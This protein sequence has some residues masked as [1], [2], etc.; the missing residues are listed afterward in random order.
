MKVIETMLKEK[1]SKINSKLSAPAIGNDL[2]YKPRRTMIALEPRLMF[3]GAAAE[4]AADTVTDTKPPVQDAAAIDQEAAK[5]AEA[6]AD[7]APPAVQADPAAQRTEILF[8]EN[9]V[10]DYQTLI[11]GAKPDTEVH[12]LDASRDGLAQMAQILEGRSGIDAIHIISHGS[13][14]SVGL[15]SLT[16]TAQNLSAHAADLET[17][18]QALNPNA[19]ILLYGCDVGKGSDGAAFIS[20][21]AQ[22]THTDIAA[23][24]DLTGGS[25][26]G[27]DWT[28]EVV[29]GN[30]EAQPVVTAEQ[31]MLYDSVLAAYT[32]TISFGTGAA[33]LNAGGYS[34]DSSSNDVTYTVS[35]Y[36]L[37]IDGANR[38]VFGGDW[39]GAFLTDNAVYINPA[40]AS[41]ETSATLSFTNGE[42][43]SPGSITI[44]NDDS[45]ANNNNITLT[46]TGSNGNSIVTGSLGTWAVAASRLQTGIDLSSI[47]TVT[48]LTI[49]KTG[50]GTFR[51]I[52]IDDFA[53]SNVQAASL[54][55]PTLSAT[56]ATP[57][58]TEDGSAVD[59]F[60]GITAAT[61]DS[62]QTFSGMTLTVTNVSDTT[63][64]LVVNGI[65]VALS[66]STSGLS[67]STVGAESAGSVTVTGAGS[68]KTVTITGAALSNANMGT[69]IDGIT[70][71]DSSQAPSTASSRVVTITG[72]TD[73]GGSSNTAS[74]NIAATVTVAAVNDA[75]T[76]LGNLT[77]TAVNEDTVSPAG[78]AISGLTGLSFADADAG[79]SSLGG[80]AVVGN[81][82]NSSTEG[83]WQYSTNAGGNWFNIGT[84]AD[85]NTAL[86]LSA[87]TL[88]R[89]VPVADYNG[90]PTALTV[91]ALDNTN[92][93][94]YSTTAGSETRVMLNS[95]V[96]GGTTAISASTNTIG[97]SITAVNDAPVLTAGGSLSYTENG[98]A[99]AIDNTITLSDV[100]DTQIA[101][102]TV[103][104]SSGFTSGDTLG[105]TDQNGITGSYNSG[106]GVLTLSG[107]ATKANYQTALRSVTYSSSSDTPT[108]S[109]SSRTVTWAVTDAAATGGNGA[110]TSTGVTSTVNL[111]AVNDAPVLTAGGSLSYTENGSAAA[112]DNTIT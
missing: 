112:I 24:N 63:E 105:F 91:R 37:K 36:T 96:N 85:N 44:F 9:N 92:A 71:R 109:S 43:F 80:V 10:T 69:L 38:S 61:N 99:A 111:T 20:A 16:L 4:T 3:D 67:L 62:G 89:F 55:A 102:A 100:D 87:A 54:N 49:T 106:T 29:Q 84:V 53:V 74:P 50:G 76:G 66:T 64:Y 31:M 78:S 8:I 30:I 95:S 39:G 101:G 72:I 59:L 18:G 73:S 104:L 26:L 77:L 108:S 88:V 65:D 98:S 93:S 103:T 12:V 60:S 45:S 11:D 7:V 5:L 51:A 15:G 47:G 56:G 90:T 68:T 48:S 94:G 75:P 14:A 35:G 79:S 28:L 70:Y 17:I 97:T 40:N 82:A 27:G 58:Y 107:T 34:P 41:G 2:Y 32:G 86:T 81:S 83:V 6:A 42:T 57:T 22:T 1:S 19:D 52:N 25:S 33:F 21:L 110:Q 46:I 23:S 13:E